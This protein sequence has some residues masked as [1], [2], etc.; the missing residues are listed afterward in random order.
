V[1]QSL[2]ASERCGALIAQA[3]ALGNLGNLTAS[4]GLTD[5]SI[6]FYQHAMSLHEQTGS[7]R[8]MAIVANNLG[9]AFYDAERYTEAIAELQRAL[10]LAMEL[11]DAFTHP[12]A[13]SNLAI[14][15]MAIGDLAAAETYL[16]HGQLLASETDTSLTIENTIT[17]ANIALQRGNLAQAQRLYDQI[18][19]LIDDL[20]SEEYG[21]LQRFEGQLL[22]AQ[23]KQAEAHAVLTKN[24]TFFMELDKIPEARRTQKILDSIPPAA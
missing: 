20:A 17:L 1:T 8:L 3:T 24:Y 22:N 5:E 14:V 21:K 4:Q 12:I 10:A 2:A 18:M 23:G 6:E 7:R 9:W 16:E 11:R 13:L 19:L 15:T